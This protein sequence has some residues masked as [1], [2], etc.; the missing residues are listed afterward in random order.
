MSEDI[1]NILSQLLHI[2]EVHL[3]E[4]ELHADLLYELEAGL[5]FYGKSL[6]DFAIELPPRYLLE[7]L[8]NRAIMEER[9]YDPEVLRR[10][11]ECLVPKLNIQQRGIFER[12][13]DAVNSGRQEL[14]FIYGH[15]G[16][17]KTFVWKSLIYTLRSHRKIVLAVA[18]SGIAA[19]LLPGGRTAHSRFKLPINLTDESVCT[20]K[21]NTQLAN[22]L[23]QTDLIIWDEAPMNDRRCFEALDRTF[24]D[25]FDCPNDLFGKKTV[26][27]GGDFRQTLPVK[28][29][30]TKHEIV[31]SSITQSYLWQHFDV[32]FLRE[33][34]RLQRPSM[35]RQERESMQKFSQWLLDVGN[36]HIG[37]PDPSDPENT[38]WVTIL[39]AYCI[40]DSDGSLLHLIDFIYDNESLQRP[41][42]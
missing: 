35:S 30:A 28:K 2:E 12:I 39:E 34:M 25:L 11:S 1:P 23:K 31:A 13:L 3:T 17:G 40:P 22:L 9:S 42:A 21:K 10:E 24:R 8:N 27:L 18:S 16:T 5:T 29:N 15:G 4:S 19:L 7:M 33:N 6:K 36:G 14:M 37:E 41:T 38:S 32:I 20:I 26:I